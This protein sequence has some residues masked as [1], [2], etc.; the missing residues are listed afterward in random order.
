MML[1]ICIMLLVIGSGWIVSPTA[2]LALPFDG[3]PLWG[4]IL[5][6]RDHRH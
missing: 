1:V 2:L 6:F 4:D 5:L 3:T